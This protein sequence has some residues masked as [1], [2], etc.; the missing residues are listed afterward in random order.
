MSPTYGGWGG[1]YVWR[2]F[3]G[4]PRPVVDA[5]RR[6]VSRAATTRAIRW[7]A[8]DGRTYTSDQATI[9]RWRTAFQHDFAARM[10]WTIKHVARREPQS[11]RGR[12]RCSQ[13]RRRSRSTRSVGT[14][15]TLDASAS[16]DPDGSALT[17]RWFFYP[18]AGTGIPGQPVVA[19]RAVAGRRRRRRRVKAASHPRPGRTALHPRPRV[20]ES[21][22][23][24]R[25]TVTPRIAGHR[26]RHPRRRGLRHSESDLVSPRHPV[27]YRPA[28]AVRRRTPQAFKAAVPRRSARR[29]PAYGNSPEE[30]P[31]AFD[32]RRPARG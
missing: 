25:A 24:A 1:R 2:Q 15:L 8:S 13:A 30:L 18:E 14:P 28:A 17:Y 7:S 4:E 12:E 19:R 20:V 29:A 31:H 3:Y 6:L 9:W 5:G 11:R 23:R 21:A 16:R 27:D 32:S 10:D 22:S 26:A